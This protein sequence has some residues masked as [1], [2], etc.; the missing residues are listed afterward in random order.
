MKGN[1]NACESLNRIFI[2]QVEVSRLVSKFAS[3]YTTAT[4][5]GGKGGISIT[6][7]SGEKDNSVNTGGISAKYSYEL[8]SPQ[9]C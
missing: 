7:I 1:V 2:Q 8:W 3:K 6:G 5:T 4:T 9:V